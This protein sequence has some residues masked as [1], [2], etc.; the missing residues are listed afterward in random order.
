MRP[1]F[2][3]RTM[4]R[5]TGHSAI[6]LQAIGRHMMSTEAGQFVS[7]DNP[8]PPVLFRSNVAL[9]QYIL[10]RPK[11]LNALDET[12][13]GLLS[14]K[15]QVCAHGYIVIVFLTSCLK[16]NGTPRIYVRSLLEVEKDARYA[17]EGMLHVGTLAFVLSI[18]MFSINH[19]QLLPRMLRAQIPGLRQSTFLQRSGL[20]GLSIVLVC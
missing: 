8:D 3:L 2:V 7:K 1:P 6:R 4:S 20:F 15:I 14:T 16:R 13:I 10:N 11:K 17:L 19:A 9:R 18:V 12:M 5:T